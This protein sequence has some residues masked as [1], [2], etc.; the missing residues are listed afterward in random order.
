[1][2]Q[3]F[4]EGLALEEGLLLYIYIYINNLKGGGF[5]KVITSFFL[6]KQKNKKKLCCEMMVKK[7]K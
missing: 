6:E 5:Q 4:F 2:V 7:G 3:L 1:M